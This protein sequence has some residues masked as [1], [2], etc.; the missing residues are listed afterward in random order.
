MDANIVPGCSLKAKS[1]TQ[2][3]KPRVPFSLK[4]SVP[5]PTR[6]RLSAVRAL[7]LFS[8]FDYFPSTRR[9]PCA[10][11]GASPDPSPAPAAALRS[12][13][14][15]LLPTAAPTQSARTTSPSAPARGLN[16]PDIFGAILLLCC[17]FA[18][19]PRVIPAR[20]GGVH[21]RADGRAHLAAPRPPEERHKAQARAPPH[22]GAADREGRRGRA[23][24]WAGRGRGVGR[25]GSGARAGALRPQVHLP[26]LPGDPRVPASFLPPRR[27]PTRPGGGAA[28][29]LIGSGGSGRREQWPPPPVKRERLPGPGTGTRVQGAELGRAA[30]SAT[31]VPQP[32]RPGHGPGALRAARAERGG[33]TEPVPCPRAAPTCPAASW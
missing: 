1:S 13:W 31:R 32:P 20:E 33:G 29:A 27:P 6:P 9:S 3:W 23:C 22:R 30:A 19:D 21:C 7:P 16:P 28:G 11:P 12:P 25:G 2:V 24:A 8:S 18:R 17:Y 10:S 26:H 15:L 4:S 5:W 14:R